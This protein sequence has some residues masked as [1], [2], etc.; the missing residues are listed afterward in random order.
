MLA[1]SSYWF[2]YLD[3]MNEVW[4]SGEIPFRM[5]ADEDVENGELG[6]A[7]DY[8]Q[9]VHYGHVYLKR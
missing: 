4:E 8:E 2:A 7:C 6:H 5:I 9:H 3:R 1:F